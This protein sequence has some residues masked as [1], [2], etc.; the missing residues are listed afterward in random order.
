MVTVTDDDAKLLY[1]AID[2]DGD[3]FISRSEIMRKVPANKKPSEKI[4]DS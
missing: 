2:E 4:N 3:G 1:D